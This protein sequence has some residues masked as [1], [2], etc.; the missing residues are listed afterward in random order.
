MDRHDLREVYVLLWLRGFKDRPRAKR[1]ADQ[2]LAKHDL[3]PRRVFADLS[4]WWQQYAR[5]RERM[6]PWEASARV[7]PFECMLDW[8]AKHGGLP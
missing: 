1:F 7:E 3:T 5:A 6:P 2:A 8:I 4:F